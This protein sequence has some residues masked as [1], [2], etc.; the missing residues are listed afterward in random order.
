MDYCLS[1]GDGSASWWP[2]EP[3]V[4]ADGDGT[5]DGVRLDVDGDGLFDD[6]LADFDGDGRADHAVVDVDGARVAFTD[7]GSGTWAVGSGLRWFG[8]DGTE[9]SGGAV[10]DFDGDGAADDRLID[11]DGNGLADR[12]L[13]GPVAYADTDGDG[14]WDVQLS[15]TDG[16]GAADGAA[17]VSPA[18][19]GSAHNG[20]PPN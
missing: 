11:A 12:V 4:D 8:L 9:Q 20:H 17:A 10:V 14:R 15:D 16:D 18:E 2:G 5:L 13:A 1:D 6:A 7:D 3:A 19:I